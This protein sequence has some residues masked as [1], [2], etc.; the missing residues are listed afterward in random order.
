MVSGRK[1]SGTPTRRTAAR[2]GTP[3]RSTAAG[4]A[5]RNEKEQKGSIWTRLPVF[6]VPLGRPHTAI[7][8]VVSLCLVLYSSLLLW[9]LFQVPRRRPTSPTLT[10]FTFL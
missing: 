2:S 5:R 6:N 4:S 7:W 8:R 3:P 1:R 10:A 9:L